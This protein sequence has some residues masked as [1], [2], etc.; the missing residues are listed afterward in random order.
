MIWSTQWPFITS[1]FFLSHASF[2]QTMTHDATPLEIQHAKE[3]NQA[4]RAN[5]P[6]SPQVRDYIPTPDDAPFAYVLMSGSDRGH[7]EVLKLREAIA[8][9]LPQGVKLVL[10]TRRSQAAGLRAKYEHWI[11][12][13]RLII[14][15]DDD[16][17]NSNGFWARDA[18]PVPVWNSDSRESSLVSLNYYRPFN[19]SKTIA[20]SV[21]A[22]SSAFGQVFVGGNILADEDGNCFS[23][24]S[25]RLF[26]LNADEIQS[27][28]G[29]RSVT[30]LDHL[31]GLGDV[32]E[33]IKP[34]AG[35]RMLTNNE[36]YKRL[37]EAQNYGV[38]MLPQIPGSYRTYINSLIVND[39]VFMPAYGVPSDAKATE[40]YESLGFKVIP[41]RSN[42]LS[43]SMHGS[44]HCQTMAYPPM[45]QDVL[46]RALG[47]SEVSR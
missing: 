31:A 4:L 29:C 11:S 17:S 18:F 5:A 2:G 47:V 8:R 25:Y 34:I 32:D 42:D 1:L 24:N 14:A 38:I 45:P 27:F 20:D 39:T 10:L 37:L 33:V 23:V 28:F 40:V 41:I 3:I 35:H 13:D 7:A 21:A 12:P 46:L 30:L 9:N 6:K 36:T 22:K 19:S 44:I 15:A 16:P 26:D 43:D